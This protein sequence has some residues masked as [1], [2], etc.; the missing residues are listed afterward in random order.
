MAKQNFQSSPCNFS[1]RL[2]FTCGGLT[3][4]SSVLFPRANYTDFRTNLQGSIWIPAPCSRRDKLRRNDEVASPFRRSRYCE[5]FESR[6]TNHDSRTT[7]PDSRTP[8]HE[9]ISR[10]GASSVGKGRKVHQS[11]PSRFDFRDFKRV[12]AADDVKIFVN[13]S[14]WGRL[15]R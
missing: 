13:G 12:F 8:S 7:N 10:G 15:F 3:L 14:R 11:T 6:S 5:D 9:P 1:F 4:R 2:R